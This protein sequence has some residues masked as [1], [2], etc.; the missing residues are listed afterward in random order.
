[1]KFRVTVPVPK[2]RVGWRVVLIAAAWIVGG[3]VLVGGAFG[4]GFG[5]KNGQGDAAIT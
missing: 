1:M 2:L 3:G 4:F 5:F